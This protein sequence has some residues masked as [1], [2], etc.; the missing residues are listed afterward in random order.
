MKQQT[1]QE[2]KF[3]YFTEQDL[4]KRYAERRKMPIDEVEDLYTA[5]RKWIRFKLNDTSLS[6]KTGF[7]IDN[8][9][10]FSQAHLIINDLKKGKDNPKYKRAEKQ[11]LFYLSDRQRLKIKNK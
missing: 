2:S 11:L 9:F 7:Y 5:F 6:E 10:L 1:T 3:N 8:F 4:I